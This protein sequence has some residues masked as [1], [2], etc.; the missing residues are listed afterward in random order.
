[1]GS[2]EVSIHRDVRHIGMY[3]A[4]FASGMKNRWKRRVYLDLF[5]GPG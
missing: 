1:M 2:A 4:L 5:A 3:A